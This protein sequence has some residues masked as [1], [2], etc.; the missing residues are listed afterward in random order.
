MYSVSNVVTLRIQLRPDGRLEVETTT[1][2]TDKSGR[3]EFSRTYYFRR[4]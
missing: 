3:K 4:Q 2:L 1:R